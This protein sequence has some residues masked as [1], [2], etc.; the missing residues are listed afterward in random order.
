MADSIPH[1]VITDTGY[2]QHSEHITGYHS[3]W[4]TVYLTV[5]S[6]TQATN[7]TVNTSQGIT[8]YGGQYTSQCHHTGYKQHSEYTSHITMV[9]SVNNTHPYIITFSARTFLNPS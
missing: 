6:L 5:S 2:K 9:S 8:P 4:W 7:S 1:S 3:V